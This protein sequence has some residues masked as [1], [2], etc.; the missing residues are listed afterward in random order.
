M[1]KYGVA[2]ENKTSPDGP[3]TGPYSTL[4]EGGNNTA[5]DAPQGDAML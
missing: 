4:T 2:L 3:A 5:G 1:L